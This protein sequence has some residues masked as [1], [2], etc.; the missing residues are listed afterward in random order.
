MDV[1]GKALLI[2]N[3]HQKR[4][5]SSNYKQ[6]TMFNYDVENL[7]STDKKYITCL[8]AADYFQKNRKDAT[9]ETD[10]Q[11]ELDQHIH[12][13]VKTRQ[14]NVAIAWIDYKDF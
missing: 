9:R 1:E 5:I 14:K 2:Q 11:L 12:K 4:T 7:N 13:K 10:D 3:K 8:K 6:I